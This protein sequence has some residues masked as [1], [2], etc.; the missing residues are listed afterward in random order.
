MHSNR[1]SHDGH[2]MTQSPY[3]P[4]PGTYTEILQTS[5]FWLLFAVAL[6]NL[7]TGVVLHANMAQIYKAANANRF[8]SSTN[9]LIVTAMSVGSTG[10]KLL[11]GRA[12]QA[13]GSHVSVL[14][15]IPGV[16]HAVSLL[17]FCL[18]PPPHLW[19]AA[20]LANAAW[21]FVCAA[22]VMVVPAMFPAQHCGKL[23]TSVFASAIF[24]TIAF[25]RF[26]FGP[27]YDQ[28]GLRQGLPP[29]A[30]RGVQCYAVTVQSLAVLNILTVV[31]ALV[32]HRRWKKQQAS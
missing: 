24:S 4:F 25:N 17:L 15:L 11:S 23:C 30:C 21:G 3:R 20:L 9:S 7:G 18:I 19:V 5:T 31:P 27:L 32:V 10:G 2:T 8:D 26:M 28:E 12:A 14:L 29:G 16:I 1:N 13:A 22:L 6:V